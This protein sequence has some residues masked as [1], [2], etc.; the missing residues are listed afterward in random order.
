MANGINLSIGAN[1]KEVQ[2]AITTGMVEPLENALTVLKELAE[3]GDTSGDALTEAMQK[4]RAATQDATQAQKALAVEQA[5]QAVSGGTAGTA[6]DSGSS[7]A[8]VFDGV[9]ES[10]EKAGDAVKE[11]G[12]KIEEGS[13]VGEA[14]LMNLGF[15]AGTA[16]ELFDGPSGLLSSV[17][18]FAAFLGPALGPELAIP[19]TV[20]GV[21]LSAVSGFFQQDTESAQQLQST[22][23]SLT[24][25]FID[26]GDAGKLST[27]ETND[28]L[29]QLAETSGKT[30]SELSDMRENAETSNVSFKGLADAIGSSNV[31]VLE[32]YRKHLEDSTAA[33]QKNATVVHTAQGEEYE[34]TSA[35]QKHLDSNKALLDS[36]N[37][38]I[39][40]QGKAKNS[41]EAYT[42]AA[43]KASAQDKSIA[44]A[45]TLAVKTDAATRAAAAQRI[46]DSENMAKAATQ[47]YASSVQDAY[48][49]AGSD[50]DDYV[51]NGKF[52]LDAYQKDL[53]KNADAIA[54]YQSNI[55]KAI[56]LLAKGGHDQAIDY[57]EKL[58][59]DAAPLIAAFIKAPAKQQA[60]LE[61]EWDTLGSAAGSS[62]ASSTQRQ[63]N[64]ADIIAKIKLEA[65]ES[66]VQASIQRIQR[67]TVTIGVNMV[68]LGTGSRKF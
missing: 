22:I 29:E 64:A 27:K 59:P 19:I 60:S 6:S 52:D 31:P 49:K 56:V 33:I 20:L 40:A 61:Q 41:Q 62:F 4:V 68:P 9:A 16:G 43:E 66:A 38:Q 24:K 1:T 23:Q 21:A 35:Q 3:S 28:A 18:T 15:S 34:Y 54:S 47:S 2:S 45:N 14:A 10:S 12:E 37:D 44:A 36:I 51:K 58:G 65:D 11:S 53:E 8:M 30:G 42:A 25:T 7:G 39:T 57:L 13:K 46:H 5:K 32:E 48:A 63:V 50:I 17:G 67:Q 55:Q 26:N